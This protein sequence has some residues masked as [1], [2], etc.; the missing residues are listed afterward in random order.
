MCA[1]SGPGGTLAEDSV[2]P[3]GVNGAKREP[4]GN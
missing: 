3:I 1:E 2:E 4:V